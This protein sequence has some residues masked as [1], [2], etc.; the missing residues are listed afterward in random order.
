MMIT[1]FKMFEN[2]TRSYWLSPTDKLLKSVKEVTQDSE[3]IKKVENILSQPDYFGE[4]KYIFFDIDNGFEWMPYR[5]EIP[6][7]FYNSEGFNYIG[8]LNIHEGEL[9]AN[10]F[11]L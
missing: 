11:N 1:K 3:C 10:K 2:N 6:E 8:T 5:Y 4:N 7:N 9:D